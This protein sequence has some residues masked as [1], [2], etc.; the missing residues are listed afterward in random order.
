M[1]RVINKETNR[2]INME[3][4]RIVGMLFVVTLHCLGNGLLTNNSEINQYNSLLIRFLDTFSLTANG[5][6]LLM[7]GYYSI[8]KKFK[9][10]R[11]MSLWGKTIFYSI[12][13]F[14]VCKIL[15]MK[16]Y[17]YNSLFPVIS[18]QHWF[19]TTY[20]MLY[21]LSPIINV[22]LNKLNK[23]QNTYL[24]ITLL[25]IIGVIRPL[26]NPLGLLSGSI[27][28]ALLTY[29][30]GAY[31]K[32]YITI[33]PK[34]LYMVKYILLTVLVSL[35]YIITYIFFNSTKN[36][37]LY[38]RLS[39]LITGIREY[40][41]I[42]IM[43][44]TVFIFMKFKTITI[45]SNFISKLISVISPSVFA[46]YLIHENINIRSIIWHKMGIMNFANSWL[47]IPYILLMIFTV[48]MIC[49]CI[50]LLR[51][52]M[53]W[54]IKKIPIINNFVNRINIKLDVVSLKINNYLGEN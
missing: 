37:T 51:R 25:V 9:L 29:I 46:V 26:L 48:F 8:D 30:L 45:K 50:D 34:Q 21:F 47:M 10:R 23:K 20:I 3:L 22:M 17:T 15:N 52:I 5:I 39:V 6:F 27:A 4:L 36:P 38:S 24:L 1:E 18:G 54:G 11:V 49:I 43:L 35:I 40:N 28:P 32:K 53:Y 2:E 7:S 44:M 16:T 13:I 12:T 41:N 33:K 42:L 19:I 14:T 31:I